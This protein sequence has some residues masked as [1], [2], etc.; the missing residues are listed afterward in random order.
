MK[1]ILL[2]VACAASDPGQCIARPITLPE[3]TNATGCH[4]VAQLHVRE[5]LAQHPDMRLREATCM[6]GPVELVAASP[7]RS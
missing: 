7:G 6:Q 1:F 2:L 3:V 4:L 5:W